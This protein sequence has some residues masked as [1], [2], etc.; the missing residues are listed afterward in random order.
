M[1]EKRKSRTL[2]GEIVWQCSRCF[3]WKFPDEYYKDKRTPNGLRSQCKVCHIEGNIR[4]RDPKNTRQINREYM[5]R[6]RRRDPDK[7]RSRERIASRR[8]KW[9]EKT[10]ARY[11][12]NLAIRRGDINRP[13][14]CSSCGEEK[15]ITA[16]HPNHSKPFDVICLC[17]ECHGNK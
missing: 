3:V 10:E 6:A 16:H 5:R 7:F 8:R 14:K 15:R 2:K 9:T 17:H 11:R 4:T 1:M 12:L 13:N